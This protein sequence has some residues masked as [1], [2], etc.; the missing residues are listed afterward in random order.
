[1]IRKPVSEHS[2]RI[3]DVTNINADSNMSLALGYNNN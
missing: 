3:I 1:M 2:Q